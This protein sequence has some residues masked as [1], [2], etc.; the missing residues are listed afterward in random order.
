MAPFVPAFVTFVAAVKTLALLRLGARALGLIAL[1][2]GIR[3]I[4]SARIAA[5]GASAAGAAAGAAAGR[6]GGGSRRVPGQ[7]LGGGRPG[8]GQPLGRQRRRESAGSRRRRG[9]TRSVGGS[10]GSQLSAP[11]WL[12]KKAVDGTKE[13]IDR[14]ASASDLTVQQQAEGYARSLSTFEKWGTSVKDFA[15]DWRNLIPGVGI[16]NGFQA[17][18]DVIGTATTDAR[19]LDLFAAVWRGTVMKSRDCI[20]QGKFDAAYD[21]IEQLQGSTG[22]W[23]RRGITKTLEEFDKAVQDSHVEKLATDVK[24]YLMQGTG[25]QGLRRRPRNR[26]FGGGGCRLIRLMSYANGPSS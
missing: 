24:V 2:E 19:D 4:A 1:A 3:A 20:T 6:Y 22:E 21:R 5:A 10:G 14:F 11:S 18:S 23:W 7:R 25:R 26:D 17:I 12:V 13:N 9:G 15:T 16:V 8:R